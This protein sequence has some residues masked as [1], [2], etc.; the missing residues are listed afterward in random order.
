MTNKAPNLLREIDCHHGHVKTKKEL[1][2]EKQLNTA[3][4]NEEVKEN[5]E[6]IH[7]HAHVPAETP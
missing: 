3:I 2:H 7:S 1:D 4:E 6:Y 5:L